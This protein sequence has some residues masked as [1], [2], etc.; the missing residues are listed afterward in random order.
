MYNYLNRAPTCCL[1]LFRMFAPYH[2]LHQI[3]RIKQSMPIKHR[4][5]G[6][7]SSFLTAYPA[8]AAKYRLTSKSAPSIMPVPPKTPVS[9]TTRV[10]RITGEHPGKPPQVYYTRSSQETLR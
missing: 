10:C 9:K 6:K 5:T 8:P 2:V 4:V 3:C 1:C 7:T